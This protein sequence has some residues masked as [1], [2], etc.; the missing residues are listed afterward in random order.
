VYRPIF[1]GGDKVVMEGRVSTR[2]EI[3]SPVGITGKLVIASSVNL[4]GH[5]APAPSNLYDNSRVSQ[6]SIAT[7][8][9][10]GLYLL[11]SRK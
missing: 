8:N 4:S 1:R 5:G 2:S 6:N 10:P 11:K 7:T 9:L 3:L